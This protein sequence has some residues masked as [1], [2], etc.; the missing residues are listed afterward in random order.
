MLNIAVTALCVRVAAKECE[1]HSVSELHVLSARATNITSVPAHAYAA[2]FI[3]RVCVLTVFVPSLAMMRNRRHPAVSAFRRLAIIGV[4]AEPKFGR[5]HLKSQPSSNL[6]RA[7]FRARDCRNN[8]DH[9]SRYHYS[10][11]ARWRDRIVLEDAL[12]S[13]GT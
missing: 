11:N 4:A 13:E 8:S 10:T 7:E 3:R 2:T 12:S 6:V 9:S 5:G 1:C